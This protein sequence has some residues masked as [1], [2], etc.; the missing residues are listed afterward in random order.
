M[1]R[2]FL[3]IV[4]LLVLANAAAAQPNRH[5][6]DGLIPM[7]LTGGLPVWA[8]TSFPPHPQEGWWFCHSERRGQVHLFQNGEWKHIEAVNSYCPEFRYG[9]VWINEHTYGSLL[10]TNGEELMSRVN[11]FANKGKLVFGQSGGHAFALNQVGDTLAYFSGGNGVPGF[12]SGIP[13]GPEGLSLP[14]FVPE[15]EHEGAFN[16]RDWG[17]VDTLGNWIIPPIYDN[18]FIFKNGVAEVSRYGEKFRID[19]NGNRVD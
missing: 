16:R 10:R 9:F 17:M 5:A 11:F 2:P 7:D 18:W 19:R 3:N 6:T 13:A 8:G 15:V 1:R 12:H 14:A 4:F